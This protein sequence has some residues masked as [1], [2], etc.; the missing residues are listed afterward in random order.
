MASLFIPS[1]IDG[2]LVVVMAWCNRSTFRHIRHNVPSVPLMQEHTQAQ[3]P[4]GLCLLCSYSGW[5][6]L[7]FN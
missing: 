5:A 2:F 4:I 7:I 3:K 1:W 6:V